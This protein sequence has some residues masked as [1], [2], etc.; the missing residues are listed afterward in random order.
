MRKIINGKR[1]DTKKVIQIGWATNGVPVTD[2]SYW[3][4]TLYR[5]P[6]SGQYFFIKLI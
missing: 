6:R 5:T 1:Y 3:K 4:A 2:L